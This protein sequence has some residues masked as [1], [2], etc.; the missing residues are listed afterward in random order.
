M[1][2]SRGTGTERKGSGRLGE[3]ETKRDFAR[4]PEPG[5]GTAGSRQ[6]PVGGSSFVVQKHDATRL[7]YDIRLEIDGAM[8]SFA[9][10][11]G[12]SY[13]PS[14]KRFAVETED[15][16]LSY[17]E[18][19]GRIP[20]GNYGAGDV[21]IWDGGT[22]ETV[23]PGSERAMRAKGHLHLRFFGEKLEGE[24]HFVRMKRDREGLAK[25]PQWL[26]FKAEDRFA[27]KTRDVV[28][29]QAASIVTGK[30]ATRGPQ[31]KSSNETV[32]S[33]LE[34]VGEPMQ[35][36]TGPLDDPTQYS[37]E[38]KFDGYR[39]LAARAGHEVRL[40][41]RRG[42]AWTDRFQP[43]ADAVA[44][45]PVADAILDGEV[46]AVTS[47]GRPSFQRLQQWAGGERAEVALVY[48]VFDLLFLDGRDLRGLPLE[49]RR[50]LLRVLIEAQAQAQ[51]H[52]G[53]LAFSADVAAPVDGRGRPDVALLMEAC[54]RAGL[55]GFIAKRKG[56]RYHSGKAAQW[57]KL[58]CTRRQEL[59]VVGYTPLTG[60]KAKVVGGLILAVCDREGRLH[61]AGKVGSGLDDRQR[62]ELAELLERDRVDAP[63]IIIDEKLKDARWSKPKLCAEVSF[64]EWSDDGKLR[65]PL[66]LG[67]RDDKS[68][69]DC[70]RED[71]RPAPLAPAPS[72]VKLS[73]PDKVLYPRDAITKRE[74]FE[75]YE[76]IAPVMLP[77]LAG[78]PLTMQRYPDGI[79]GEAWYQHHAADA[80]FFRP[81][82]IEGKKNHVAIVDADGLR[83]AANLAALTLHQWSAR[84]E[85]T[86]PDYMVIDLDPGDGPWSHVIDVALAVRILLDKL[87]LT[88]CVKTTGKR[89]LHIV[90]PIGRGA[91]HDD[92][93]RLAEHIAAAV[94]R[95]MPGIATIER[96]IPKR[97]GRLYVDFLQNG[98]GKTIASPYTLR[99]VDGARVSTPLRW[100]EVGPGLDPGRFTLRTV[101]A[102]VAAHGDL[103]AA[104]LGVGPDI[105]G[106]LAR[107]R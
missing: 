15:H 21:L 62:R 65:H 69:L 84:E 2:K 107:L 44:A 42:H 72:R 20:D 19:E 22:Y 8:M 38:V 89:G 31:R 86:Q 33:L 23:P 100:S 104:V 102:R 4:T 101:P 40:E 7:H 29:E 64:L 45:L 52:K 1:A 78:R 94:A 34:R 11:R 49:E 81:I 47:D 24:W 51:P 37:F 6:R 56:S 30:T 106:L 26:F 66:F 75:Y 90:A 9:V 58:K 54:R 93:T 105:R 71:D 76:A 68:P 96:S 77:H 67:I 50:E 98:H 32:R 36:M 48:A 43:I 79:D 91:T 80:K 88:S 57:V 60:R 59:A 73:N 18:F 14:V 85:L 99:A 35:A 46:C 95:V 39:M 41:S 17:N 25:N 3:Y 5:V 28:R 74:I 10:P 61:Y 16:P 103:F 27:S 12:P 53:V 92:S 63:P 13:D 55:E 83:Y 97:N 70:H 87:E 82:V